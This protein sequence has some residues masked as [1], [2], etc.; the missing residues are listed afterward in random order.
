[1]VAPEQFITIGRDKAA[2]STWK[3]VEGADG[4][5]IRYYKVDDPDK[6]IKTRYAQGNSKLIMGFTNTE[7]Y[8]AEICAYT[9]DG[10]NE[11]R[12]PFSEKVAFTP[13][14]KDLT[15][16][17][18]VGIKTG[19]KFNLKWEYMYNPPKVMFTSSDPDVVSVDDEGC[20]TG[21][22]PGNAVIH[23][24]MTDN[25]GMPYEQDKYNFDTRVFVDR[26]F[27]RKTKAGDD[28]II[29]L[30]GDIMCAAKSQKIHQS[31]G[32]DFTR[33]F[34]GVKEEISRADYSLG[35]LATMCDDSKVFESDVLRTPE[36]TPNNNSPSTFISAIRTAG[37]DGLV[38]ANNHNCDTGL[39]GLKTTVDIIRHTGMDNHGTLYDNPVVKEING[40]KVGFISLSRVS[41]GLDSISKDIEGELGRYSP[42]YAKKL[43]N[44]AKELGADFVIAY[45]YWGN[46]NTATVSK[47][48]KETAQFLANAG[49]DFIVGAEPHVVQSIE[50]IET[51]DLRRVPCIYSLGNFF[52]SMSELWENTVSYIAKLRITKGKKTECSFVLIPTYCYE[53]NGIIAVD[54]AI[55]PVD[56]DSDETIEYIRKMAGRDVVVNDGT[57]DKDIHAIG[58]TITK[59]I[60][61]YGKLNADVSS[62]FD[63]GKTY[64]EYQGCGKYR[65]LLIDFY[66]V[67]SS[68]IY[69]FRGKYYLGTEA[70]LKSDFYSENSAMMEKYRP[71]VDDSI[72]KPLIRNFV[73][74]LNDFFDNDNIILNRLSFGAMGETMGQLRNCPERM[75]TN[76]TLRKIEDYFIELVNP[77]VIDLTGHY[78]RDLGT[79]SRA[80]FEPFYYEDCAGIIKKIVNG[81]RDENRQFYYS[82][83]NIEIWMRRVLY[84][85]ENMSARAYWTWLL[86]LDCA[87]DELIL[88][89]SISFVAMYQQDIIR[90]KKT[91]ADIF[92]CEGN[93]EFGDAIRLIRHLDSDPYTIMP[94]ELYKVGF[95]YN[96]GCMELLTTILNE[97]LQK[98]NV[99]S[100]IAGKNIEKLIAVWSDERQVKLLGSTLQQ[101][102]VDIWGSSISRMLV[103]KNVEE[104]R[105]NQYIF[106]QPAV[107]FDSPAIDYELPDNAS[108]FEGNA[109]RAKNVKSAFG[110]DGRAVLESN[111]G[112]WLLIDFYDLICTMQ[113]FRGGFFETD[114]FTLKTDFYD[115]I[116]DECKE[117][118][119][120]DK[121]SFDECADAVKRFA[122]FVRRC[123]DDRVI[124]VKTDLKTQYISLEDELLILEDGI[125]NID[126]KQRFV[127]AMENIFVQM[128]DCYVIDI[129]KHFYAD[130]RFPLGGAD[131]VH[132]E[133][134]FY[135]KA[136]EYVTRI[137]HGSPDKMIDYVDKSYILKRDAV[138]KRM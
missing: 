100:Y 116:K 124:L 58:S 128:S 11:V 77:R 5:I 85:Y 6:V 63:I 130:D 84:Y 75:K 35:V 54:K 97:E 86:D 101:F 59:K 56:D 95:K 131:S 62:R 13:M 90:L 99:N 94:Y 67:A 79:D 21:L 14:A 27:E 69:G 122:G 46:V 44:L 73:D 43:V 89:T 57:F 76:R 3:S 55:P 2:H 81:S 82:N 18:A 48:Q 123:Y 15:A 136:C 132:Y 41:N 60:V 117:C 126:R 106:Q 138:I 103:G 1:M 31:I 23:I 22:K 64:D 16:Q 66:G 74:S 114:E 104:I 20:L 19:E 12:G 52:S 4:Y 87:A 37:F 118:Y 49:V 105:V 50:F 120:F 129:A 70:F 108:D 91:G 32:Y 61:D 26:S 65:Y 42:E 134:E 119:L 10:K 25:S 107:C 88:K 51:E 71:P 17:A 110:R 8:L 111:P 96:F 93:G 127:S 53:K 7:Q 109:W 80:D 36:G 30:V 68:V 121:M 34:E 102:D 45:V 83:P 29:C 133:D 98:R 33:V 39:D 38:T 24:A 135:A 113:E 137:L 40:I 47:K 112:E 92:H 115:K 9:Y 72:W 28:A 125:E 78:F